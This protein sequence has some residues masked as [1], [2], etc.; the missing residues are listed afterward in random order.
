MAPLP[1]P[2]TANGRSQRA[3]AGVRAYLDFAPV[4]GQ[5]PALDGL[6][7][8][9]IILVLLRHGLMAAGA[10]ILPLFGWNAAAP[11]H[12]GWM[13]VDLF[14][15]LSGYLIARS[16][17]RSGAPGVGTYLAH[18]ALRIVPAYYAVLLVVAFGLV[19]GYPVSDTLWGIRLGYHLLFL[20]DYLPANFVVAFWSLGVE[21][22]FYLLAP[23][24]VLPLWRRL[25]PWRALCLMMALL[26]VAP[27]FRLLTALAQPGIS[28]YTMFF[29]VFRSPFHL[30][31]DA[32]LLG[33][34]AALIAHRPELGDHVR[35]H[36]GRV[37]WSGAAL[38]ALLILPVAVLAEI[39]LFDKVV[40]PGLIALGCGAMV[41]GAA[42]GGGP[43][44]ALSARWLRITARLSY[45]LYLVHLTVVPTALRVVDS[46]P[47]LAQGPAALRL[48]ALLVVYGFLSALAALALHYLVEKPGLWFKARL[49]R[50]AR[51]SV[52]PLPS[53]AGI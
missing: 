22:K 17:I 5:N 8:I 50:R 49:G 28:D 10:P 25:E 12:N 38:L 41:L 21:E 4:G 32:L 36:A 20:Q 26:L 52:S 27:V 37:F 40:Q 30:S 2:V 31:L 16:L 29:F 18:R 7:A 1:A 46:Q 14:F 45:A 23:F 11:L 39:T 6:R 33:V 43:V 47:A 34:L 3:L 9:A 44:R 19:P 48:V 53:T 51:S 35:P 13:G 15:A 24:L 42:L